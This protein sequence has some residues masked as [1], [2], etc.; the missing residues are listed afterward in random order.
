MSLNWP[1]D[2]PGEK[3]AVD[4]AGLP[5]FTGN[6]EFG[7]YRGFG[8]IRDLDALGR[9]DAIRDDDHNRGHSTA[10]RSLSAQAT[11]H[12][13]QDPIIDASADATAPA[14]PSPPEPMP[15]KTSDPIA[16]QNVVPIRP[17]AEP[18][19]ATLTPVENSAFNELA[20]RLSERLDNDDVML[21][22]P[23][24][25][26]PP[27]PDET[28]LP[29]ASA[30]DADDWLSRPPALAQGAALR[31]RPLLDL[32]PTGVLVYRLDRLLYANPAFL[33]RIGHSDLAALEAAGGLDS[34]YVEPGVSADSSS[35]GTG[36]FVTIAAKADQP[37]AAANLSSIS[38]DG[39]PALALIFAHAPTEP[40]TYDVVEA[41]AP[42]APPLPAA[43]Q[44]NA[45]DLAAILDTA[46]EGIVMFDM[47]GRIHSCNRS[48]EA[49]FGRDGDTLTTS[50]LVDLF[51]PE[52]PA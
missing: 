14:P 46:A 35:A 49:L 28:E 9:L 36:T 26:Q 1:V 21:A 8:V 33:A 32:M 34:L 18:I 2:P 42:I 4:M 11:P 22:D 3:L 24:S 40:A 48:A 52:K 15:V 6:G 20:R 41:I 16:P 29:Q 27:E 30:K 13:N 23:P 7:G 5:V 10:P 31:D 51:A 37:P 45:E 12:D 43:G 47:S 50:A 25:M 19:A 17:L 38:W 39:E 44:A